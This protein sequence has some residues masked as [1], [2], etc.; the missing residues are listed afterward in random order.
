MEYQGLI[1]DDV[2]NVRALNRAWLRLAADG[3]GQFA[4]LD[5]ARRRRLADAPFLLFTLRENETTLWSALLADRPQQDLF[6]RPVAADRR[7]LQAACLAYLW[8]LAHRNPFVA[9][10]V[11][12]VPLQWCELVASYP[13]VRVLRRTGDADLIRPRFHRDSPMHRR[14][15][16]RGG[17]AVREAR[18]AAQMAAMQAMLTA[19]EIAQFGRLPAAACRLQPPLRHVADEV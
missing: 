8:Q 10:I 9:R 1:E 17:S 18:S 6:A 7:D 13:L 19:A 16:S 15:L 2:M 4:A 12:G 3:A 5:D 11:G 14:L